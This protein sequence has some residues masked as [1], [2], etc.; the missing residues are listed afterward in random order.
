V[1]ACLVSLTTWSHQV[2]SQAVRASSSSNFSH[3]LRQPGVSKGRLLSLRSIMRST[4]SLWRQRPLPIGMH[5]WSSPLVFS[6]VHRCP[7]EWG[8][9]I[10]G[11]NR[12]PANTEAAWSIAD[13]TRQHFIL[14]ALYSL[15]AGTNLT[16]PRGGRAKCNVVFRATPFRT[17]IATT[18][19]TS[20]RAGGGSHRLHHFVS[21]RT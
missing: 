1:R 18:G 20:N 21:D 12:K 8:S 5:W 2:R 7:G 11:V 19:V 13:G 17:G 6:L 9:Q 16:P 3:G 14:A 4:V 10:S 15:G